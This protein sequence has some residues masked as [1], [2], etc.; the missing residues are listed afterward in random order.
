V[1]ILA[2]NFLSP[3]IEGGFTSSDH[4]LESRLTSETSQLNKSTYLSNK[5]LSEEAAYVLNRQKE[6]NRIGSN[7]EKPGIFLKRLTVRDTSDVVGQ[8]GGEG[9]FDLKNAKA[10]EACRL[11]EN[12]QRPLTRKYRYITKHNSFLAL[13]GFALYNVPVGASF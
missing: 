10:K 4:F 11:N 12:A 5:T 6:K 7:L 2:T 1:H 8:L 13:S 9:N 3:N